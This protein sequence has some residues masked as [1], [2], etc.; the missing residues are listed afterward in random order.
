MDRESESARAQV[1]QFK[2]D[3]WPYI[4]GHVGATL[5]LIGVAWTSADH[6]GLLLFGVVHHLATWILALGFFLPLR[7]KGT[8]LY[9]SRW[10]RVVCWRRRFVCNAWGA[11]DSNTGC[12]DKPACPL[13]HHQ[14]FLGTHCHN[15]GYGFLLL[16]CCCAGG[17]EDLQ[18]TSRTHFTAYRSSQSSG[19][20]RTGCRH[21]PPHWARQSTRAEASRRHDTEQRSHRAVL[22]RQQVQRDQ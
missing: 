8:D 6:N 11:P 1:E 14:L 13:H 7:S 5:A 18:W 2:R 10:H 9:S 12:G 3:R 15:I 4:I 16:Q 22:R 17:V 21:R 19:D 20:R